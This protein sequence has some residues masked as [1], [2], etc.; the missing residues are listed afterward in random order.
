MHRCQCQWGINNNFETGL[1]DCV[2][3]FFFAPPRLTDYS[4]WNMLHSLCGLLLSLRAFN[5]LTFT[6]CGG[7]VGTVY[8]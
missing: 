6:K 4:G 8:Y 7:V 1:K 2:C 5:Y 3:F